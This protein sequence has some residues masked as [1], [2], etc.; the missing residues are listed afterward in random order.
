MSAAMAGGSWGI[1]YGQTTP[2]AA[3]PTTAAGVA[4][5][6]T[7]AAPTSVSTTLA[8]NTGGTVVA[9]NFGLSIAAGSLPGVTGNVTVDITANPPSIAA[10][11]AGGPSTFSPNGTILNV[12]IRDSSG[13]RITTFP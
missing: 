3:P 5:S 8:A 10:I 12:D 1:A 4:T 9:G 2:A 11:N 6:L 13:T 7:G